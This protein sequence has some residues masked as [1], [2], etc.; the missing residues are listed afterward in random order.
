MRPY[1][2]KRA[3]HQS[4]EHIRRR[5]ESRSRTMALRAKEL[6]EK[7]C[8]HCRET[9]PATKEF[10]NTDPRGKAGLHSWCRPCSAESQRKL[11]HRKLDSYKAK[12]RERYHKNRLKVLAHYSDGPPHCAC[13]H[14]STIEFL[15]VDHVAGNGAAHRREI[16]LRAGGGFYDWLLQNGLPTGYRVLCFNC[17][18]ASRTSGICPHKR[19]KGALA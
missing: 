2:R 12:R 17:N 8:P 14:E 13:C 16:G 6:T 9:K 18:C 15:T 3:Y 19:L 7:L 10:F 1:P 4:P 11:R 5:F